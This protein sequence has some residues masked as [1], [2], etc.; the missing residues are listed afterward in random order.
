MVLLKSPDRQGSPCAAFLGGLMGWMTC[1]GGGG[2]V[3]EHCTR[4][5]CVV[6]LLP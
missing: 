3:R 4:K 2:P 5:H 1:A 6:L